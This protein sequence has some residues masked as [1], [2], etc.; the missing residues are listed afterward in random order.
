LYQQNIWTELGQHSVP[1]LHAYPRAFSD[2][3][4][5]VT[6]PAVNPPSASVF[7]AFTRRDQ[8]QDGNDEF[9]TAQTLIATETETVEF[10]STN[11]DKDPDDIDYSCQYA[12]LQGLSSWD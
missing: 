8:Q 4:N 7:H 5:P 12:P 2:F 6:F 3:V 1:R 9:A 11:Q 10:M